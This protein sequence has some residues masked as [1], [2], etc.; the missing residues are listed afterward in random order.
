MQI[1]L[2]SEFVW[3]CIYCALSLTAVCFDSL[4]ILAAVLPCLLFGAVDCSVWIL[5]LVGI[6]TTSAQK[7]TNNNFFVIVRAWRKLLQNRF[8]K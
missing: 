5:I 8:I 3:L 4:S 2:Y 6:L 1:L 7:D